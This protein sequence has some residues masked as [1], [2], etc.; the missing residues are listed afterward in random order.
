MAKTFPNLMKDININV[1]EV[2]QTQGRMNSKRFTLRHIIIKLL[3]DKEKILK[4]A[5][6]SDWI[7]NGP[8]IRLTIYF[9]SK[10]LL[11][12]SHHGSVVNE[13]D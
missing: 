11:G 7:Y 8:S 1:Q 6:K 4:A 3:K 10:T 2:Q 9:S 5:R 12:S 13:S